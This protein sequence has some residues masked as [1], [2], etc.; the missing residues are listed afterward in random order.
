MPPRIPGS[1]LAIDDAVGRRRKWVAEVFGR[2]LSTIEFWCARPPSPTEPDNR[3]RVNPLDRLLTLTDAC[4]NP[5]VI[6]RFCA[7]HWNLT[8][9]DLASLPGIQAA[10]DALG[11]RLVPKIDTSDG[12]R[13]V[14]APAVIAELVDGLLIELNRRK[15]KMSADAVRDLEKL[16]VRRLRALVADRLDRPNRTGARHEP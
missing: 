13:L 14:V 2:S 7:A 8:L 5:D 16:V 4:E 9:V 12:S 15:P 1:H 11:Q 3:G 6:Q 10:A